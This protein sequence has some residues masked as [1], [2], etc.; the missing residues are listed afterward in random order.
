VNSNAFVIIIKRNSILDICRIFQGLAQS[1]TG[2]QL[3]CL[4]RWSTLLCRRGHENGHGDLRAKQVAY[5]PLDACGHERKYPS[6]GLTEQYVVSLVMDIQP[7]GMHMACIAPGSND[8]GGVAPGCAHRLQLVI[9]AGMH[10]NQLAVLRA[11]A[12]AL[13]YGYQVIKNSV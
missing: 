4:V 7:H 8:D 3:R 11:L 12:A 9:R 2:F 6:F 13:R 5:A 10:E 1:G